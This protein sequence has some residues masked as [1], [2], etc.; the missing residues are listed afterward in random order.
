MKKIT[1]FLITF[2]ISFIWVF[3]DSSVNISVDKN[4]HNTWDIFN[5]NLEIITD[6]Q[7]NIDILEIWGMQNFEIISQSQSNQVQIIHSEVNSIQWLN[8][9][10]TSSNSWV[11]LL[12]PAKIQ[13]A[14]EEF[15]S[16][17][18]EITINEFIVPTLSQNNNSQDNSND[19]D[20]NSEDNITSEDKSNSE[21]IVV[22]SN[23]E[24]NI[25]EDIHPV[26]KLEKHLN[27]FKYNLLIYFGLFIIFII[28]FYLFLL[29]I[30]E[31]NKIKAVNKKQELDKTLAR[32]QEIKNIYRE[33]LE[34][35][36][37][38]EDY[39]Q[40]DF[41]TELNMLFRRYFLYIW[42]PLADKKTLL[43]LKKDNIDSKILDIFSMSYLYEFTSKSDNLSDRKQII[44][45]FMIFLKK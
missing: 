41:Y 4:T 34:L 6:I 17:Q 28:L 44:M 3:A 40:L 11:Y 20:N 10:I 7:W 21:E 13:I 2:F 27:I 38:P 42:I 14:D 1:L 24:E 22:N 29:K 25:L 16:N 12:W 15:V 35:S 32:E 31:K 37:A 33:L 26:K 19:Q 5:L 23:W 39:S 43:E 30:R 9:W 8:L 18:L 36:K 45:N